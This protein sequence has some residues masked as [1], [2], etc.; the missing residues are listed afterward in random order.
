M[1]LDEVAPDAAVS[2]STPLSVRRALEVVAHHGYLAP[3]KLEQLSPEE[4]EA[5]KDCIVEYAQVHFIAIV[6][7]H[8]TGDRAALWSAWGLALGRLN[9]FFEQDATWNLNTIPEAER[10][11]F[12]ARPVTQESWRQLRSRARRHTSPHRFRREA[13]CP[14]LRIRRGGQRTRRVSRRVSSSRRRAR[15][16]S[17]SDSDPDLA[18]LTA[19]RAVA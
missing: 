14:A 15:A 9:L 13:H 5:V 10:E 19:G 6:D 4:F 12:R 18:A 17:H 16:P 1:P 3:E 8:E 7:A 2:D 11:R